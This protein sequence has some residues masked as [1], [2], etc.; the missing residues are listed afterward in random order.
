MVGVVF[1]ELGSKQKTWQDPEIIEDK[2][3]HL[4]KV[5]TVIIVNEKS[6]TRGT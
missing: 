6:V 4:N 5:G 1:I 2:W 3:W